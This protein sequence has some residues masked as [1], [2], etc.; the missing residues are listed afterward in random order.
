MIRCLIVDDNVEF[1]NAARELLT[2][3]GFDVVGMVGTS[4]EALSA[5][6]K[7]QPDVVL[8]D[9]Y[10]GDES[11]F[12]LTNQLSVDMSPDAPAVILI[13]TYSEQDLAELVAVSPA[14]G[15]M[16]KGSLSGASIRAILGL[17]AG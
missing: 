11:G 7:L 6:R 9:V 2:N 1:L 8:V 4:A 17:G 10:L 14:A 12:D 5:V 13:S 3:E 16:S 15:F